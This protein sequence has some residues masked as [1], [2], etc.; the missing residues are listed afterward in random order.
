MCGIAGWVSFERSLTQEREIMVNM[1]AT[2][3]KRGPDSEGIYLSNNAL[4]GHRRL[5]VVDPVGG[6]QPMTRTL[7]KNKYT[8]VYNGE[9]YN[10]EE[11]RNELKDLGF[12]FNSYS[13]TEVL[14][15]SYIAW[16][17]ECVKHINGIYAFGVW[18]EEKSRLFLARDPLGV[19]PLF[20][21]Q[22]GKSIIFGSEI[23]TLLAHPEVE[24]VVDKNGLLEIFALGPGRSPGSGVFK[25]IQEIPPAHCMIFDTYGVNLWEYWKLES[26]PHEENIE[27][28]VEHTRNLLLDAIERQLG[29]DVPVCTFLSGGLDSSAISAVAARY[30]KNNNMGKLNTYSID[31]IDNDKYFQANDFQPNSDEAF[32]RVMSKFIGS[33]HH[34]I[35]VNNTAL[36]QALKEAVLANDLPGMADI[37]S[38]LYLF[39]KEVRKDN[40]VALSGECA[41]EI[42][43]G[44]P[45]YRREEDINAQTFPW[46]RYVNERKSILSPELKNLPLE[47]YTKQRYQ[48]SLR[49]V[50]RLPGESDR[51]HRMRELFYLNIKWFMVTLLNRKDRMSM[52]NSLEVRV[53][54]ADYRIVEYAFNVPWSIKY[55]DNIEKGLLRRA[56]K[57]I[58]PE[59]VLYRRKSPY[60]KTHNPEYLKAVQRW[61]K[62]ILSDN[63]SPI[64][65]LIDAG[66]VNEIISTD[67][68]A[69]VKPWYG[70]LMTGPQ[71]LA[72]LIQVN[73]WLESYKIRI[74]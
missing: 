26:K 11:L 47:E 16:G 4:L 58:L 6:A 45:W 34:N 67:G 53:P 18:E 33:D 38:S 52:S 12:R 30:F 43:G 60:P 10:T 40:V 39:C 36:A 49:K 74:Q 63:N 65:N 35:L 7:G 37:D 28:T 61:M 31:Y 46:S 64:L 51:E 14:L 25:D 5:V 56:L 15:V 69:F 29:A 19:K 21:V 48:D 57:G 42:F 9:L 3:K 22:K 41:D 2:L 24:P 55:I 59:E 68:R 73:L 44:Y 62:E 72:Y 54:F 71:L 20:Y 27:Q 23:K 32:V 13:D 17:A 66:K 8:L 1:V 70:Q 50:P